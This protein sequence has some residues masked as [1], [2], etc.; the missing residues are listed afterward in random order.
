MNLFFLPFREEIF[1]TDLSPL[2]TLRLFALKGSVTGAVPSCLYIILTFQLIVL[3]S[4]SKPTW[5][6]TTMLSNCGTRGSWWSIQAMVRDFC[7]VNSTDTQFVPEMNIDGWMGSHNVVGLLNTED[8]PETVTL[9]TV[10]CSPSKSCGPRSRCRRTVRH[11]SPW[12]WKTWR[13]LVML[14]FDFE[15]MF[16][17]SPFL[18]V[19]FFLHIKKTNKIWVLYVFSSLFF[20][21]LYRNS[22]MKIQILSKERLSSIL[23]F[24]LIIG[25]IL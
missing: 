11:R 15:L 14:A 6:T 16:F 5:T 23:R 19:F 18:C 3:T 20:I 17:C 9:C 10:L 1:D 13:V 8:H 21:H 2:S 12:H 4:T 22:T 25:K 7:I 24:I